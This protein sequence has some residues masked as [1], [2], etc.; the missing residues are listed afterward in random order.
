MTIF[1]IDGNIR[2]LLTQMEEQMEETGEISDELM[3]DLSDLKAEK[4]E[5]IEAIALYYK[6][7]A[8]EASA[9]DE[10][11]KKLTERARV[12]KNKAESLKGFLSTILTMDGQEKF[13]TSRVK[14]SYRKSESVK[15]EGDDWMNIPKKYV[16]KKITFA[17][18]KVAL[19]E[20]L[21]AGKKIKGAW[22]ET[23]RNIQIK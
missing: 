14:V 1:D 20:D 5:K 15:I 7:K 6:E 2:S 16:T 10:E 12:A 23:N 8:A 4:D 18:D 17:A 19:K 13:E 22:L 3:N 9:I 11:A 21:K